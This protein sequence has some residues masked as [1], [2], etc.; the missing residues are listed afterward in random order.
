MCGNVDVV[1]AD[2]FGRRLN[3]F[4][5]EWSLK[6]IQLRLCA[7]SRCICLCSQDRS[8]SL[9]IHVFLL[10]FLFERFIQWVPTIYR[11]SIT[12]T[13]MDTI[14]TTGKGGLVSDKGAAKKIH[15]ILIHKILKEMGGLDIPF[16]N[17]WGAF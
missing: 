17:P 7:V 5:V 2:D 14:P 3:K 16:R 15:K 10:H 12:G 6:G 13:P 4:M 1:A 9:K 11:G 8:S